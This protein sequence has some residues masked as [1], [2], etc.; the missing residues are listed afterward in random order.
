MTGIL[1]FVFILGAA[2]ILHEFGHFIVAKLLGIRVETFSVGFGKRL[3]GR[4]WG[5]TDYRLSLIPLGG[6]VK[7]GGD[8]SNAGIEE[9]NA[10]EIPARER[11]DLRPRWQKF[12]VGVAGPVMNILTALAVPLALAMIVGVA[13]MPPPVVKTVGADS[14][15][16]R[17]GIK[18]GDRIVSFNGEENSEW[19]RIMNDSL[20]SPDQ[21]LP[22]EVERGGQRLPL[23]IT[24]AR[25]VEGGEAIGR[26]GVLPD[27]G[28][29]PVVVGYVE[30]GTPADEAGM[31]LG[32]RVVSVGGESVT[33]GEQVRQYIRSHPGEPIRIVLASADGATREITAQTRKLEDGTERLGFQPLEDPPTR[34][35]GLAAAARHAVGRNVE[36]L[37]LT[38]KALAQVFSGRRSV[39]DTF[40]GPIGIANAS[41]RAA[42]EGG[43]EGVF[44]MLGFVSLNLGIFNLLP[45]PVLDGGMIFMVF[46]EGTLG[47]IGMK[48]SMQVR[49]RIQQVGF[50]FLLLLMGFVIINDVTKFAPG[51]FRSNDKPAETQQK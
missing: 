7:L 39:R 34:R 3:W 42:E 24:P 50:V 22:L 30:K 18:P 37:R 11:F 16:E 9:G 36:M 4:R 14:A 41:K 1:A 38:G 29:V 45:I 40:S 27:Y 2:V 13:V 17:A 35:L 49:E 33:S 15:A 25:Q 47:L 12:C 6:Y 48:L 44:V 8:D 43:W 23:T 10:E 26:L 31:K 46:L 19:E 32:E 51:W 28:D 5:T 21:P 20:L